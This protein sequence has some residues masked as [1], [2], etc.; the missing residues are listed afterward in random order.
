M[1]YIDKDKH[2]LLKSKKSRCLILDTS[3]LSPKTSKDTAGVSVFN[4]KKDD[5]VNDVSEFNID[6]SNIDVTSIKKMLIKKIP[7][8][9]CLEK[10]YK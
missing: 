8:S 2:Y 4:L 6:E 10:K 7:S 9:G 1:F 5:V 3:L